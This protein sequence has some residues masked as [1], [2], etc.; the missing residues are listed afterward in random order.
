MR[1]TL[2][3]EEILEALSNAISNKVSNVIDAPDV[4]D[5]WFIVT[6]AG[7]ENKLE[8]YANYNNYEELLKLGDKFRQIGVPTVVDAIAKCEEAGLCCGQLAQIF[9]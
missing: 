3:D 7:Q 1:I 9:Q 4:E 6:K 2:S 8:T 5:C